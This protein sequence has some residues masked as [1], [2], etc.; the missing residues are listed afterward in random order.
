MGKNFCVEVATPLGNQSSPKHVVWRKNGGDTVKNVLFRGAQEVRKNIKKVKKT[1]E[2][3]ISPLCLGGPART[4]FTIFGMWGHTTDVITPVKFQVDRSKGLGLG[5]PK[6]GC[7][8]LTLIVA[9]T[10]VLRTTV[11]HCDVLVWVESRLLR[12]FWLPGRYIGLIPRL[13]RQRSFACKL[14]SWKDFYS[15]I[16]EVQQKNWLYHWLFAADAT[17]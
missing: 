17:Q 3:D 14:S 12:F 5:V 11:L 7:F 10:T 6:I 9:L 4:I 2:H 1:F 8:P 13:W 16:N 15:F